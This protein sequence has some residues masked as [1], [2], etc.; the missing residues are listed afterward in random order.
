M[1]FNVL[2]PL[3]LLIY[4]ETAEVG[5]SH[6]DAPYSILFIVSYLKSNGI[7]VSLFDQRITSHKVVLQYIKSYPVIHAGLFTMTSP[8]IILAYGFEKKI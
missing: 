7:A 1:E 6:R 3:C 8:Q 5:F 4:P 2:E